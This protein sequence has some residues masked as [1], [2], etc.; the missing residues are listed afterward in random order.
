[1]KEEFSKL[2]RQGS[3]RTNRIKDTVATWQEFQGGLEDLSDWLHSSL[4]ELRSLQDVEVFL[5]EFSSLEGRLQ[6]CVVRVRA[7]VCSICLP[8]PLSSF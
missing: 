5:L 6:V 3:E 2:A 4:S 7:C 1:M 8:Y